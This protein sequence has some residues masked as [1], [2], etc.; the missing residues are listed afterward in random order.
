V[1]EFQARFNASRKIV[2]ARE[3]KSSKEKDPSSL[4]GDVKVIPT[5]SNSSHDSKLNSHDEQHFTAT[6]HAKGVDSHKW[7]DSTAAFASEMNPFWNTIVQDFLGPRQNI[8]TPE[9]I[10]SDVVVALIDDGVDMFDTDLSNQVLE[11]KSFDFHGVKMRP[12]FSSAKG[13]GTVMASM[14]LRVCP[15]AKLYPIRL[16]TY[17]NENGKSSIDPEYA[18]QAIQ[19]ALDK[20][21]TIISMSWTLP[22]A[23]GKSAAKDRRELWSLAFIPLWSHADFLLHTEALGP[24][25]AAAITQRRVPHRHFP[26]CCPVFPLRCFVG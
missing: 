6:S 3:L 16:K 22:M 14:I 26:S 11:G 19:A 4:F 18:A 12:P 21:A 13:H 15:M 5:E 23:K 17:D 25:P 2:R 9:K 10:E 1:N 24:S 8:P 20:K 7:L